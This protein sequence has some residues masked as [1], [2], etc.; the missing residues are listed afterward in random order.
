MDL[1][2]VIDKNNVACLY[3]K[4][5]GQFFYNQGSG[6]FNIGNIIPPKKPEFITTAINNSTLLQVGSNA[7]EENTISVDVGFDLKE[8]NI[9]VSSFIDTKVAIQK[10][11]GLIEVLS[12]K[13]SQVGS[14]TNRLNSV[15][16]L[17]QRQQQFV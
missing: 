2:P 10:C 13:R 1:I 17:L 4:V 16:E 9:N 3:D 7:G 6:N 11:D 14:S 5:S 12:L 8:F 15:L